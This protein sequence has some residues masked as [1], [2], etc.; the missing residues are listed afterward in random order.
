[1]STSD[2][3]ASTPA[4]TSDAV[5][6]PEPG[7]PDFTPP[8]RGPGKRIASLDWARG[9][10]L[11]A[12][13]SVNSLLFV[14][15]WFN[16]AVWDGVHPID[17][18]FPMFVTLSGCG[19][20]FAMAR[21]VKVGPLLRRVVV[22]LLLGLVYNAIVEWSLDVFTWRITGVLQLYAV[23]VAIV[24][25]LH[26]VTKT[27]RG[28]A[29]I[30]V[31]LA[32][33]HTTIL[34]V[35]ATGCPAGVLTRECNPSGPI[36]GFFFGAHMYAQGAAGHDP[37]GIIAIVGALVSASAGATV[38]H[39]LLATRRKAIA[40]GRGPASATGPILTAAAGFLVLAALTLTILP[41]ALGVQLPIMKRLWTAPFA[42]TI[43]AGTAVV[44]LLGHILLDRVNVSRAVEVTSYP[45]LALGRNSLLVYFGSHILTSLLNRP[46]PDGV[47]VSV[48]IAEAITVFGHP[49]IMWTLVLLLFWI[50]LAML[51]H[52]HRIYLRP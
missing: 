17:A 48:H 26:L 30:T 2:A 40:A 10:M 14:P 37:E 25:L 46:A 38:G 13:V 18:V 43:A 52:R 34:T 31:L 20:A 5:A 45:L 12:S 41:I 50:G 8:P 7:I 23:L 22:L 6:A 24:G 42:L 15:A 49:Q 39:L 3:D 29:I 9:W 47:P 36:D 11:I 27:W 35:Y 16:H 1:M 4:G 51:L 28:W 32:F 21:V 19:L 33:A 44:L